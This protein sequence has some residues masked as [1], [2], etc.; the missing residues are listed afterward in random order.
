MLTAW[1]LRI[2]GV[3]MSRRMFG[4]LA[5]FVLTIAACG[6]ASESAVD[7]AD[8]EWFPYPDGDAWR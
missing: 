3:C 7:E 5:S 8:P 1:A 6:G 2:Y 4:V